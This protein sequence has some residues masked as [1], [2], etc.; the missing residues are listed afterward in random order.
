M[1]PLQRSPSISIII[2]TLNSERVL[3]PCLESIFNQDYPRDRLE[4]LIVD[5]GSTDRTIPIASAYAERGEIL[6][7]VLHNRL[8]TAE[9]GKAVGVENARGEVV[10]FIDSDNILPDPDWLRRMVEPFQDEK[11][12]A[13]E[14]LEYTYRKSDGFITRYC[15]LLGM[16]DPLCLFIGNYDRYCRITGRWTDLPVVQE[17][18][19]G[20]LLV[21]L[22]RE[23]LPT[24]GA[25]GFLIRR[26]ALL[27]AGIGNYLFD[28]DVLADLLKTTHTIFMAKVKT[29]IVHLYTSDLKTFLRKQRRRI[30]DY[31]QYTHEGMRSYPWTTQQRRGLLRFVVWSLL[32][33]PLF[34]QSVMG[35]SRKFDL[36]WLFHPL[37]CW[38]T[39]WIY[40]T[41]VIRSMTGFQRK[42][43]RAQW[44]Q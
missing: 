9:A 29:G 27:Q 25:N 8:Q 1:I 16:N 18:R 36:C 42:L 22:D 32:V 40:G 20:Y 35:M 14:P 13:S 3:E 6:L 7:Q 44:S 15:A 19:E 30:V 34:A 33:F 43:S 41:E 39:L 2:P 21:Q 12:L 28:I 31:F 26:D 24:I 4:I 10:A 5:G 37:A 38:A 23:H 17:E 11:I